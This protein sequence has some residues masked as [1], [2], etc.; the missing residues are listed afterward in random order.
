MP[1]NNQLIEGEFF[2]LGSWIAAI[3]LAV[4]RTLLIEIPP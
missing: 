2:R 3:E 4:R 1:G